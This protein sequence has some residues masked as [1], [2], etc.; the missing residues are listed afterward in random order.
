VLAVPFE[1][2]ASPVR[3][4]GEGL[5][6]RVVVDIT[7]PVEWGSMDGLVTPP[8]SSAAEE[9]SKAVPGGARMVKAF[10]TTFAGI[11]VDRQ[12]A[13]QPLDVF[14]AGDDG[15][16]GGRRRYGSGWWARCDRR[17]S[18]AP[19]PRARKAWF[20]RDRPPVAAG[21]GLRERLE[22]RQLKTWGVGLEGLLLLD[23]IRQDT[24]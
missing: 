7:N 23:L 3:E 9:I 1:A 12:V 19:G 20:P 15:G 4:Y 21:V 18:L 2:T 22:A 24:R 16:Q 8:E 13:G 14:I 5:A 17:R 6:G 11:L 10:N